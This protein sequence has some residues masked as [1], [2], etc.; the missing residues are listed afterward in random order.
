[1]EA[2]DEEVGE[3]KV[4][5]IVNCMLPE[6]SAALGHVAGNTGG[7]LPS[8]VAAIRKFAP[9]M[10]L[11]ILCEGATDAEAVVERTHYYAFSKINRPWLGNARRRTDFGQKLKA[12]IRQISPD[13]IHLHGTENGYADFEDDVWGDYPRVISLQGIITAIA[14]HY[15]GNLTAGQLR[16]YRNWLRYMVTRRM[17]TDVADI[18]R[19]VVGPREAKALAKLRHIIG[20]T[21]WDRAWALALA[22]GAVYHRVGEILRHEFYDDHDKSNVI[23]HRIFASAAFKY[24]LKGG[25]VLLQAIS[26]LKH[27]FPDIKVVAVDADRKLHPRSLMDRLRM[28]E[29]H[30]FLNAEISRLGLNENVEVLPSLNAVSVA[31]QI[32]KAEVFC[33]P[34][35]I[36]NSPN[37]LAEAQLVG[38][39]C[40]ATDVGG[41]SSMLEN[42]K[43]GLLVPSGD[44]A[45]LAYAIRRLFEDKELAM[46]L[47]QNAKHVARKRHDAEAIVMELV[48]CYNQCNE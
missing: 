7:W 45:S 12:L 42:E 6:F 48:S 29:Y 24:P 47:S 13:L 14:P 5:W 21:D 25:H 20:R 23:P 40:V 4:L 3:M 37:S 39:P 31:D 27:D 26:Y 35:L 33:L 30:Y 44:A 38:A 10:E 32:G 17:Q 46:R 34:S 2:V 28:T 8:L 11:H 19:K 18:W 9:D 22:P 15:M 1:M 41:V 43:T 36:E 16:P